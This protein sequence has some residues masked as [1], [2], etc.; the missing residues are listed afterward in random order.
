MKLQDAI[1]HLSQ[2]DYFRPVIAETTLPEL[3]PT[4][5]VYYDLME[6]IVSQQLSVKA[7]D[8][9]FKR[10]L[11]L[12]PDLYPHPEKVV[13]LDIEQMRQVGLSYQKSSYLK[14][15]ATFAIENN[16]ENTDWKSLSDREIIAHL[17]QIKG[18]GTWTVQMILIFSLQ[19]PD[20]FPVDDLGVQQGVAKLFQLTEQG[21]ELKKKMI[22][23]SDPWAP[24]RSI[25][26]RLLWRWKDQ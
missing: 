17:T 11:T 12:F 15:V 14:N 5:N 8:T 7:A 22:E 23:L 20:V 18:V 21:K 6:S 24:Y 25:A 26:S 4:G 3:N 19:R 10:Y 16:I 13:D 9:I 2:F 1:L